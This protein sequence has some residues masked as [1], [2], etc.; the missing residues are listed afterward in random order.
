MTKIDKY[1]H[2]VKILKRVCAVIVVCVLVLLIIVIKTGSFHNIKLTSDKT[3]T[4]SLDTPKPTTTVNNPS[5]FGLS[6][7]NTEYSLHAEQIN[8]INS[9]QYQLHKVKGKY[10]LD[11]D[12]KEYISLSANEAYV[13]SSMKDADLVENVEVLFSGGYRLLTERLGINFNLLEA[14]TIIPVTITGAKGKIIADNGML[15]KQGQKTVEFYGPVKTILHNAMNDNAS[16]VIDSD[17]LL[18]NYATQTADFTGNAKVMKKDL[19]MNCDKII[20]YTKKQID[21]GDKVGAEAQRI[22]HIEF[23]DNIVIVQNNKTARGDLGEYNA[24]DDVITLVNNVSL[25]ED[26]HYLEGDKLTY[27]LKTEI[28]RMVS[29]NKNQQTAT[30]RVRVLIPDSE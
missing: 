30:G 26:G 3:K 25:T 13:D 24:K 29:F 10:F 28:A 17:K 20:V 27:N 19:V 2:F 14:S 21:S 9:N 23:F 15:L 18:I 22:E 7:E 12:N 6:A 11:K 4:G 16:T 1:S 8:Q 5:F